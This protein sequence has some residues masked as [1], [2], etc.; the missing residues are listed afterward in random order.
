[1]KQVNQ[2]NKYGSCKYKVGWNIDPKKACDFAQPVFPGRKYNKDSGR[3]QP[4]NSVFLPQLPFN[5]EPGY[6]AKE[7]D[8]GANGYKLYSGHFK[9]GLRINENNIAK[10][11][12]IQ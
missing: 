12:L 4:Y 3:Y 5:D 8:T 7:Q 9:T 11:T 6:Q 2:N 1:M 10:V